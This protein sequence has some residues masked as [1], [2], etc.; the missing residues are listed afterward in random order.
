MNREIFNPYLPGGEYIP[1]GEPHVF[2]DWI[3]VYG[4]HDRAGGTDYC[5]NDYVVW[6]APLEEL[7]EWKYEG[8]IYK[9]LIH[10]YW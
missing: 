8:I 7:S 3:Y 9:N 2:G 6:S 10:Q 1:D 5:Q 4:S